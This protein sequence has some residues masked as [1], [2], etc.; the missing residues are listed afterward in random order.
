MELAKKL[1]DGKPIGQRIINWKLKQVLYYWNKYEG[2]RPMQAELGST[3]FYG[4]MSQSDELRVNKHVNVERYRMDWCTHT[5]IRHMYKHLYTDW[6]KEGYIVP[7]ERPH[8]RYEFGNEVDV[9]DN[10]C[11]GY[12]VHFKWAHA[13]QMLMADEVSHN[14]CMARDRVSAW[15]KAVC[16]VGSNQQR[17]NRRWFG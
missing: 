1:V 10:T 5:N 4:F 12:K 17:G 15:D 11:V 6:T 8:F 16:E 7:L 14:T 2:I 9:M 3:W 13:E